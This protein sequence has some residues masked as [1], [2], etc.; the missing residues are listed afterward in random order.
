M[1]LRTDLALEKRE[2]LGRE[3]P[4]GVESEESDQGGVKFT[5]IRVINEKGSEALGK[6]IG[7][8]ITS[9]SSGE[10]RYW[11]ITHFARRSG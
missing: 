7:T 6:P 4:E 11:W 8:Y 1:D 3:E 9:R 10:P 2:L 5:K